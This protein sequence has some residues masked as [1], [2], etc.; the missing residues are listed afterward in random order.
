MADC[1][2]SGWLAAWFLAPPIIADCS[3]NGGESVQEKQRTTSKT[4]Q[5]RRRRWTSNANIS[6]HLLLKQSNS[7]S[8]VIYIIWIVFLSCM[9]P[10]LGG[11][12]AASSQHSQV[13]GDNDETDDEQ[14]KQRIQFILAIAMRLGG[15]HIAHLRV[16]N[17]GK[18]ERRKRAWN[19]IR[20]RGTTILQLLLNSCSCC[21]WW[22]LWWLLMRRRVGNTKIKIKE[23]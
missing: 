15:S 11:H 6:L 7:P 16:C 19:K 13:A 21:F 1:H 14:R 22:W 12:L 20:N 8:L 9:I 10:F 4:G 5:Q 2:F 3:T 23:F 17:E 18:Q